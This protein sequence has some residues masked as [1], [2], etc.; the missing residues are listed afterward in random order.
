MSRLA[1]DEFNAEVAVRL[2]AIR[3]ASGLTQ[4]LFAESIGL[5]DRAY[6]NY[7][8]GEREVPATVL[9]QLTE[10]YNVDP[11]WVLR[12]SEEEPQYVRERKVDA[13]LLQEV[14]DV[15]ARELKAAKVSF[16]S[17]KHAKFLYLA[18]RYAV[19]DQE[20]AA[21][22]IRELIRIAS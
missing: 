22:R 11:L 2:A 12:G 10:V 19:E 13:A 5:S 14:F 21:R 3:A 7:E 17:A 9:R 15:V 18:Y 8:R 16:T 4:V 1:T 6:S 20:V